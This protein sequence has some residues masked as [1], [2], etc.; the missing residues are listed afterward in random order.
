MSASASVPSNGGAPTDAMRRSPRSPSENSSTW[1]LELRGVEK[2]YGGVRALRGVDFHVS[3][4]GTVH[5]LIGEN[6]SGKSTLLGVMAGLVQPD[7][8]SI[9]SEGVEVALE[10]PGAAVRYGITTVSQET[11]VALDLSVTENVLMGR[12]PRKWGTVD[13]D[14]ARARV[15]EL[16]KSLG[17]TCRPDAVVRSLR[18]D[19]RQMVEIA[20]AVSM[21]PRILIL[22]EPTSSL[23]EHEVE[24][25][26]G[27]IRSLKRHNVATILVSHRLHE[28]FAV[29]DEVT[30]LRDGCAVAHGPCN[31]FTPRDLVAAMVGEASSG[32]GSGWDGSHESAPRAKGKAP[33]LSVR[34]LGGPGFSGVSLD[35]FPGEIVGIAGLVGSG[36]GDLLRTIFGA[37]P[38]IAGTMLVNGEKYSPKEPMAAIAAGVGYV[39]PERKTDG[40]VLTMS[41]RDNVAMVATAHSR[42]G[43][44]GRGSKEIPFADLLSRLSVRG[45]ALD[46]AAAKLSGG[47]QQKIALAKWLATESRILLLAEPTRG[48]DVMSRSEIHRMV[49]E[50]AVASGVGLLVSS[51]ENPELLDI[52]DRIIVM[53]GG[54]VMGSYDR[55]ELGEPELAALC[56]GH[57]GETP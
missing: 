37:T 22:D 23:T 27:A 43:P 6:G 34:N 20:R 16:L 1:L 21:D 54:Q 7:E 38:A 31:S 25:V 40:L 19:E 32:L 45:S 15:G 50:L 18:P 39:P 56:G 51:S 33:V 24:A 47:N 9:Y 26:L 13:W 4:P 49:R 3:A 48:V 2:R 42:S 14:A 8:G 12:L 41:V 52:C 36:R 5:G 53:F 35:L 17:M 28:L 57:R 44:L 46:A 55:T 10:D 29:A 30:V 11:A